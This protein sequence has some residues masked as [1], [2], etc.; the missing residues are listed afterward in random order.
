MLSERSNVNG[1]ASVRQ[2]DA[3]AEPARPLIGIASD[4]SLDAL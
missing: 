2:T 3:P 1:E 4:A